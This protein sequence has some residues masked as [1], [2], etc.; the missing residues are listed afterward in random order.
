M[1]DAGHGPRVD[2]ACVGKERL[3]IDEELCGSESGEYR[4]WASPAETGMHVVAIAH[5]VEGRWQGCRSRCAHRNF[6]LRFS[7]GESL[8]RKLSRGDDEHDAVRPSP[9][10][11]DT[12]R[13]QP[14]PRTMASKASAGPTSLSSGGGATLQPHTPAPGMTLTL[15]EV[16]ACNRVSCARSLSTSPTV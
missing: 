4:P 5:L 9:P 7:E 3:D 10:L 15:N 16:G 8:S 12:N 6:R 14:N 2:C 11:S 13:H 1:I